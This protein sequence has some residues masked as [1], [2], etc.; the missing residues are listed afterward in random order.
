MVRAGGE[1]DAATQYVNFPRRGSNKGDEVLVRAPAGIAA[2]IQDEL[3]KAIQVAAARAAEVTHGVAVPAAQHRNLIGRGGSRLREFEAEH[4]VRAFFPGSKLYASSP[5]PGNTEDVKNVAPEDLVK[6]RGSPDAVKVAAEQL[7]KIASP[8]SSVKHVAVPEAL[9]RQVATVKFL[10]ALRSDLNV[11]VDLP[12][13]TSTSP[14]SA[15]GAAAGT[16]NGSANGAP[17]RIDDAENDA[18]DGTSDLTVEELDLSVQATWTLHGKDEES[19]ARAEEKIALAV[20]E[21]KETGSFVGRL[22]VPSSAVGLVVGRQGRTLKGLENETGARIVVARGGGGITITGSEDSVREAG[23][24][25]QDI[26][27]R[28]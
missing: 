1:P 19:L 7:A 3:V 8:A 26:V 18:F 4:Q 21:A 25:I 11:T 16:A 22:V 5:A 10:R 2:K 23:Q 6:L 20:E 14:S 27:E 17:A 13:V 24:R 28:D 12:E 9:S 15:N